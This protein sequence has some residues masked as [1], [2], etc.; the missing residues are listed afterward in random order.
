MRLPIFL[1][2]LPLLALLSCNTLGPT[3]G[4]SSISLSVED[5]SCTEIWLHIKTNNIPLPFNGI[6]RSENLSQSIRITNNDTTLYLNSFL[7]NKNYTFQISSNLILSNTISI[8]TMDTTSHNYSWQTFMLGNGIYSSSLAD[9]TIFD[10]NNLWTV[11]Q[12]YLNDSLGNPDQQLYNLVKWNGS[13]FKIERVYYYHNGPLLGD[14]GAIKAFSINDV[15]LCNANFIHWDGVNYTSIDIPN[16]SK[17]ISKVWGRDNNNM[18]LAGMNGA[19]GIYQGLSCINIPTDPNL[20]V[21]DIYGAINNK[22][23]KDEIICTSSKVFTQFT[24]KLYQIIND[25]AIELSYTG[26]PKVINSIWF[27]PN[28]KYIIAGDGV[29]TK[30]NLAESEWKRIPGNVLEDNY[31]SHTIYG[32]DYNNIFIAGAFGEIMHFNGYT[33]K[34]YLTETNNNGIY[35][36]IVS[37]GNLVVAVG[38]ANNKAIITIG[39][40]L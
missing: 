13:D 20:D 35:F 25:K 30:N 40:K 5:A 4:S 15:Y 24:G 22:T 29:Y 21:L 6:V 31:M 17:V 36:R 18:Y 32:E 37:K 27:K 12:L 19:V 38:T 26:L 23:G 9:I 2:L 14:I 7:P 34:N 3:E 11:G 10:D 33:W 28:R 1:L 39:K 8:Q 16:F